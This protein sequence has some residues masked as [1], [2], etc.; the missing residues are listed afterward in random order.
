MSP[1]ETEDGSKEQLEPVDGRSGATP[2]S[3]TSF[4]PFTKTLV[5][6]LVVA[7]GAGI[8]AWS[9]ANT[10]RVAEYQK[11]EYGRPGEGNVRDGVAT[12]NAPRSKF[13]SADRPVRI[14]LVETKVF[15]TRN[16]VVGYATLGAILSLGLG[17]T[18]GL[19]SGRRSI[20]LVLLA[21]LTGLV[22]G[23]CL[24][25]ASSYVLIPVYFGN[26]ETADL[27]FSLLIHLGIWTLLGAASGVAF[28]IG[29]GSRDVFV[30]SIIGGVTGAA[31]ATLLF[32]VSGAFF[33]LAHT[34]RPLAEEAGTR[35]AGTVLLG[36]CIAVGIV[37]V[38]GQRPRIPANKA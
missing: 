38:A 5:A 33:P 12:A 34:E 15:A 27:T 3:E 18:A 19:L 10:F 35:L 28:G 9:L 11:E 25:A 36:L 2:S 6:A 31:L 16:G 1:S 8:V 23:A 17:V 32:D 7:L 30:R 37:V 29:S 26:L 4:A 14:S 13:V 21:G 24:G 20:S 22:L